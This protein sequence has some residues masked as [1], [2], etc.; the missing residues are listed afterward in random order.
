MAPRPLTIKT[1]FAVMEACFH[2]EKATAKT[3]MPVV[4]DVGNILAILVTATNSFGASA[5]ATSAPTSAVTSSGGS[6]PF[7]GAGYADGCA[8]RAGLNPAGIPLIKPEKLLKQ[9]EPA[10]FSLLF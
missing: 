7:A 10:L 2:W 4:G 3:Y 1:L 5:P 6:C 9:T 8:G